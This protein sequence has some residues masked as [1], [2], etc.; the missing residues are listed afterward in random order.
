MAALA[1]FCNI[2]AGG[3]AAAEAGLSEAFAEAGLRLDFRGCTPDELT[4]LLRVAVAEGAPIVG[5]AGGD[6]TLST[7]ASVLA[8]TDTALAVFPGGTLNH[9]AVA[10]GIRSY[11]DAVAALDAGRVAAIDVGEVNGRV[12][13]NGAS[14]GLYPQKLRR[15]AA[16]QRRIGKW[17]AAALAGTAALLDFHRHVLQVDSAELQLATVSPLLYV[18]P[19]RGSFQRPQIGPRELC[20]E[21]LELV[22]VSATS[23]LRLLELALRALRHGGDGLSVC[24]RETDCSVYH[25]E[26]FRVTSWFHRRLD[27]GIDGELARLEAPLDFRIRPGAL[28]VFLGKR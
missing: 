18:G 6:G 10:L 11:A 3:G 5:V 16:W 26:R 13:I 23:R 20:S 14:I 12:F 25:G 9:F 28:R 8:G 2:R 7:A 21:T 4:R 19:G 17:P 27:L 15:R 24:S 22:I 1:V